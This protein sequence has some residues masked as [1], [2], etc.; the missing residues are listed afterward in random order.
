MYTVD[1]HSNKETK[2]IALYELDQS[3][4]LAR[5][6]KDKL[7]CVIVGYGSKN[8]THI[9][10]SATID[11]LNEYKANKFIKDFI[12]GN[13]L[14]LFDPIYLNFKYKDKIPDKEK[15]HPNPGCIYIIV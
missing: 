8:T 15:K 6:E 11:K 5:K 3:I 4:K 9:I 10:K 13:N 2:D 1:I 14:D 12:C 7:L